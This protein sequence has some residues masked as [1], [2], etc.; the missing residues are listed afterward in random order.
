M[1]VFNKQNDYY[2]IITEPLPS[3][4]PEQWIKTNY[5]CETEYNLAN[6]FAG[7]SNETVWLADELYSDECT[8]ETKERYYK[9]YHLANELREMILQIF[10]KENPKVRIKPPLINYLVPIMQRNGYADG[11]GWWIRLKED[12]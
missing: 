7:A 10:E 11:N 5:D 6:A 2:I 8:D 4:T 1:D 12:K 3:V 9:W